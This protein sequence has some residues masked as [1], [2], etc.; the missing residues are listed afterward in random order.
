MQTYYTSQNNPTGIDVDGLIW[1][2]QGNS[3]F[4][5]KVKAEAVNAQIEMGLSS[6]TVNTRRIYATWNFGAGK[7]KVG[8]DYTPIDQ[9]ISGQV[10]DGDLGLLGVGAQYGSRKAQLGLA[11]G[12]F[13]IAFSELEGSKDNFD[14]MTEG[15]SKHWIPRIDAKW[16]MSFD[17][18]NFALQGGF[19][20]FSIK[21]AQGIDDNGDLSNE[22]DVD[23]TSY[24]VGATVGTNFGPLSLKAAGSIG[25]NWGNAAWGLPDNHNGGGY[26][27]WKPGK[28]STDD[29][30]SWQAALVAGFKLSDM[31]SFEAGGGYRNDNPGD[32]KNSNSYSIYGQAVIAMAPGVYLIP[33]VSYFAEGTE[34][35]G[36]RKGN[37]TWIGGKWQIDF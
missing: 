36:D 35:D 26:A 12:G 25:E 3:R 23:V 20:T 4:G 5:A 17:T 16:G 18:W 27:E 28:N 2:Q 11:F 24:T 32:G 13:E 10:A 29:A 37:T 6:S 30:D 19:N 7:L 31:L 8:K 9:F 22:K 21:D 14:N 1:D 15:E 34:Q 33:E